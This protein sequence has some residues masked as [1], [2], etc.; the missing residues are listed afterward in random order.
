MTFTAAYLIYSISIFFIQ[1][2]NIPQY[3][4]GT[5][6]ID[7][8]GWSFPPAFSIYCNLTYLFEIMRLKKVGI[9]SIVPD[10]TAE[11]CN[12]KLLCFDKT[13]TIT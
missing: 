1:V 12:M 10:K 13:G 9:R 8:L 4:I 2:Q 3:Q 6:F 11:V 7:Y 5:R